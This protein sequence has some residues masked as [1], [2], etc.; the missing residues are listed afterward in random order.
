MK[1]IELGIV[2]INAEDNIKHAVYL[3][4]TWNRLMLMFPAIGK[5]KTLWVFKY[6]VDVHT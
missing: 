5:H 6:N 3:E 1:L 2:G 4:L